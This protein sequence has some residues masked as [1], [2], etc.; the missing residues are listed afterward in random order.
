MNKKRYCKKVQFYGAEGKLVSLLGII[1]GETDFFIEF[2]T[3]N[4]THFLNKRY[5][6]NIADTEEE[7]LGEVPQ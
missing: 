3:R 7:F 4:K 1:V 2:R 5:L 6:K